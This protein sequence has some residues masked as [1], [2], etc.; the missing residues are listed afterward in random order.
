MQMD[1]GLITVLVCISLPVLIIFGV[2]F[3]FSRDM[4]QDKPVDSR[5]LGTQMDFA[6][7]VLGFLL[8]LALI[9]WMRGGFSG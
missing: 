3:R 2:Y 9:G 8:L 1:W 5:F 7:L 4:M 6:I